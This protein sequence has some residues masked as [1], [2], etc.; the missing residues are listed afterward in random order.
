[1]MRIIQRCHSKATGSASYT[2]LTLMSSHARYI[3]FT[4]RLLFHCVS[5]SSRNQGNPT[6]HQDASL[7]KPALLAISNTAPPFQRAVSRLHDI[8]PPNTRIVA[9]AMSD[10]GSE[11]S[12]QRRRATRG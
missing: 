2:E 11:G 7:T 6:F 9:N 1:M 10:S 8:H 3:S 5:V 12:R 4:Q